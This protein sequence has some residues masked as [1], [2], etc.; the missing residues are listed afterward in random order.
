MA[1]CGIAEREFCLHKFCKFLYSL[2]FDLHLA[3]ATAVVEGVHVSLN[4]PWEPGGCDWSPQSPPKCSGR[5]HWCSYHA[6]CQPNQPMK[7]C[8]VARQ[9]DYCVTEQS[10]GLCKSGTSWCWLRFGLMLWKNRREGKTHLCYTCLKWNYSSLKFSFFNCHVKRFQLAFS[11]PLL[12]SSTKSLLWNCN[13]QTRS[14]HNGTWVRCPCVSYWWLP[15]DRE[16]VDLLKAD[17][18]HL[19]PV[20]LQSTELGPCV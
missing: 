15:L 6:R 7:I 2:E 18:L 19:Q 13:T 8:R 14:C 1:I 17:Y 4:I 10:G 20:I 12:N 16:H 9:R 5:C 3:S 11:A